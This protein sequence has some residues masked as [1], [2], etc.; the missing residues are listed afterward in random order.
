[1]L[2]PAVAAAAAGTAGLPAGPRAPYTGRVRSKLTRQY[3]RGGAARIN[4]AAGVALGAMLACAA[5]ALPGCNGG[6]GDAGTK[7]AAAEAEA[8]PVAVLPARADR[9]QR[10][11]EVIGTLFGQED[12]YI[13]NKIPG[14]V[15]NI[16]VDIG[17]RVAPGQVLAQLLKNDY[18]LSL[19]E[20]IALL[21][22]SLAALGVAEVPAGEDF[23]VETVPAVR[24]AKLEAQNAAAK[25]ERGRKL[26][27]SKPPLIS[28]QDFADLQTAAQVAQSAYQAALL[29]ARTLVRT[30][31]TR[32]AQVAIAEQV[33]RDTTIRAP[34]PW[35]PD[36]TGP[37]NP[38]REPGGDEGDGGGGGAATQP[39]AD[40][41]G[42]AAVPPAPSGDPD[43][44][45][46]P[47]GS[48]AATSDADKP[49][50]VAARYSSE[51]ELNA[52]LT[53]MFRLVID[54]P[55][56]MRANVPERH[57]GRI[58]VGQR[59]LVRI[60]SEEEPSTGSVT[61]I[62]PQIDPA[63]RTFEVEVSVPNPHH[64]LKPGA[65]AR[66]EIQTHVQPD[67]L[68][69]PQRSVISFAGVRKVFSVKDGKAVEITVSTGARLGDWVEVTR[70]KGL[71]PGDPVVVEGVN[72]MSAG[73]PVAVREATAG[74]TLPTTRDAAETRPGR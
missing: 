19:N 14:R 6:E 34:R 51:G 57:A 21:E 69:V 47:S 60:E 8:V 42:G 61:R 35:M 41:S 4:R 62:N 37:L 46:S 71:A 30:A 59:V 66:A 73:V 27:E 58:K 36:G 26:H 10:T 72:R 67:V 52:G 56:K 40:A 18:Q 44:E 11:V 9:V 65:F 25:F 1:M 24:R 49:Y 63:N 50:V 22:E 38:T 32:K 31:R 3:C 43:A 55:L 13:S 15:T 2:W 16:F 33:M 45:A 23:D 12:T 20:K 7:D 39:V 53:R 29:E 28:D 48:A 5:A 54:D 68:L 74:Q 64:V 17:D 70:A